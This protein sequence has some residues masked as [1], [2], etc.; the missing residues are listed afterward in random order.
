MRRGD[1]ASNCGE[2][3]ASDCFPS[4]PVIQRRVEEVKAELLERKGI[5]AT[6]VIMTSDERDLEWWAE[7]TK[8]GWYALDH[9]RTVELHGFWYVS[10]LSSCSAVFSSVTGTLF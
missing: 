2:Y 9:S 1:F 8:L 4:F 7:V 6:H 3:S 10:T 5:T